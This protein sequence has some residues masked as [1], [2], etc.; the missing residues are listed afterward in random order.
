MKPIDIFT[1]SGVTLGAALA[2]LAVALSWFEMSALG[3]ALLTV[4]AAPL[5]LLLSAYAAEAWRHRG[6][7]F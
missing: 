6:W 2:W 3:A 1:A 7:G 4:I 5:A